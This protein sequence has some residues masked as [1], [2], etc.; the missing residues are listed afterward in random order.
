VPEEPPFP[1]IDVTDWEITN[2]ETSGAE[3]KFW[4]EEPDTERHWLF[5]SVTIK[6]GHVHGEDWAEKAASHLGRL[7]GIPCAQVELAVRGEAVGSI[8]A[9]LRPA[10]YQMQPGQVVLE[11]CRAPGYVHHSR[12]KLHPGHSL[13]NIR[14]ALAGAM[15]PPSSEVP[16]NASAF[17]IFAG[18]V[19]FDAWIAN[20]D[21][22]DNNWSV[23]IPITATAGPMLLSGSYDHARSLAFNEQD[24][25][26]ETL[27]NQS[28]GVAGWCARGKANRFEGRPKLAEAAT[29]ALRLASTEAREYWPEQLRRVSD[30]DARQVLSR[31]PRMSDVARMFATKLLE[32]N[33]MGVLNACA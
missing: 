31:V 29:T 1:I 8:S 13:E 3:A 19:L 12:G 25:R 32:A 5:K 4:L 23:L 16:F 28:D 33:R 26:R 2:V 18:Y 24:I 20:Q 15:A 11:S 10:L 17:D 7:M 6:N 14:D 30:G 22:H 9:N 21:R 27:L